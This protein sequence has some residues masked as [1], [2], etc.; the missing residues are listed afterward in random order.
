MNPMIQNIK[1]LQKFKIFLFVI[2]LG[3]FSTLS[4][5]SDN[6]MDGVEDAVDKCQN[7]PL[8]DLV[9]LDGCTKK[10]L[11]VHKNYHRFN[12]LIGTSYSGYNLSSVN[13]SETVS[14]SLK[15]GYAY[16]KISFKISTSYF[17]VDGNG[18]SNDGFNDSYIN[19]SYKLKP[20]KNLLI[21][22]GTGIILPTYDST[23]MNNNIDY[24]GS[25]SL[26]YSLN[27]F[28]IFSSYRYTLVEDE[29]TLT[30]YSFQ[31]SD[32][33]SIGLGYYFTNK[34]YFSGAYNNSKSIYVGIENIE[35]LSINGYKKFNKHWFT[36]LFYSYGISDSASDQ[37]L[38]L[39]LG[40][41]F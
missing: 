21:Y 6:D 11:T 38:S 8:T 3:W 17:N 31:N 16:K 4:A 27:K 35:S 18:Y 13:K 33:T 12:I 40:Y 15:L 20:I 9:D 25:I 23:Q 2:T 26:N 36:L 7:T 14:T 30:D 29:S 28:S 37:A 22:L 32:A 19:I 10:V 41:S 24:S 34:L 5:Y 39:K 1:M